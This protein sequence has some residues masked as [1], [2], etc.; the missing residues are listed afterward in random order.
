M[1][2]ASN[3]RASSLS[4]GAALRRLLRFRDASMG[5]AQMRISHYEVSQAAGAGPVVTNGRLR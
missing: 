4:T 3:V 1:H 5:Y 2:H